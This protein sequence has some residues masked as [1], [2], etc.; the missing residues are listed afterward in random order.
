MEYPCYA[1]KNEKLYF[2]LN[3]GNGELNLY[4][5]AYRYPEDK[6]ICGE[7]YDEV[8]VPVYCENPFVR[9]AREKDY[10]MLGRLLSDCNYFLGNGNGYTG[11][12]YYDEVDKHCDE[13][14]KL[15]LS[16]SEKDK[17]EWIDLDIIENLRTKML[18]KRR[19]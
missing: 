9:H 4:T 16:F 17:P 3:D 6:D 14:K 5:G 8:K 15:Y 7:P 19:H 18:K 1:D 11:H 13:M 12:L 10:M 2:D